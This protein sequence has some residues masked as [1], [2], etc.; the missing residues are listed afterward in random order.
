MARY[1]EKQLYSAALLSY[2]TKNS[3]LNL[4]EFS[5]DVNRIVTLCKLLKQ[6]KSLS[7]EHNLRLLL[8][9]CVISFNVFGMNTPVLVFSVADELIYPELMSLFIFLNK[10]PIPPIITSITGEIID[11]THVAQNFELSKK[12]EKEV[13]NQ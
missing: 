6:N 2:N 9:W 11:L 8:N 10:L 1:S 3:P 13:F 7:K 5:V 4:E 12:L